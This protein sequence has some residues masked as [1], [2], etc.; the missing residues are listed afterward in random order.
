MSLLY[1]PFWMT[2]LGVA[3]GALF[4]VAFGAFASVFEGGPDVLTGIRESWGW[5]AG[6]GAL[7]AFGTS[8]AAIRDLRREEPPT[9]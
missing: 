2:L 3:A 6:V 5:F 7:I 4:G 1:R 8:R 9:Y